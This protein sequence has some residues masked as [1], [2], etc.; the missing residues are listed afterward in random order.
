MF[1]CNWVLTTSE[2]RCL[3]NVSLSAGFRWIIVCFVEISQQDS[4][5][6]A[7]FVSLHKL[8]E[9]MREEGKVTQIPTPVLWELASL[10]L[11]RSQALAL[12]EKIPI[13]PGP[14][15]S[16]LSLKELPDTVFCHSTVD[17]FW[18]AVEQLDL[19][20]FCLEHPKISEVLERSARTLVKIEDRFFHYHSVKPDRDQGKL[21]AALT[22]EVGRLSYFLVDFKHQPLGLEQ[23]AFYLNP[24]RSARDI[25]ATE[26]EGRDQIGLVHSHP[27][28]QSTLRL[29][30]VEEKLALSILLRKIHLDLA[31][32]TKPEAQ[33]L[34]RQLR[35][36]QVEAEQS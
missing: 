27:L 26:R 30:Q 8:S 14:E 1:L 17:E 9:A 15:D 10:V 12:V 18:K 36:L 5:Y 20:L 24:E 31:L 19:P 2:S 11:K 28:L 22:K 32:P 21:L 33:L 6:L 23:L 35:Q 7:S 16:L 34:D 25:E 3:G 13:F 29:F 4:D